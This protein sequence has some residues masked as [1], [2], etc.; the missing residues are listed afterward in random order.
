[1]RDANSLLGGGRT[2]STHDCGDRHGRLHDEPIRWVGEPAAD[3]RATGAGYGG[4]QFSDGGRGVL[5]KQILDETD[6]P[7]PS[8]TITEAVFAPLV[9]GED[10]K[11]LS[12]FRGFP[13]AVVCGRGKLRN[14]ADAAP[15]AK[16]LASV[17]RCC[18]VDSRVYDRNVVRCFAEC[19][20]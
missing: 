17:T 12:P 3:C 18:A 14:A 10:G 15:I 1:M 4:G 7:P 16:Y 9:L 6:G 19:S 8:L 11:G 20:A 5:I 13:H 2:I